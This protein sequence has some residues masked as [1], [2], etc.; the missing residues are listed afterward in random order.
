MVRST[1]SALLSHRVIFLENKTANELEDQDWQEVYRSFAE[2]KPMYD[3]KFGSIEKFNFGHIVTEAFFMFKI[4]FT[5]KINPKMRISFS[6]RIFEIKRIINV[7]EKDKI[8]QII[9]LE[10]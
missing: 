2:I 5:E 10:I 3:N 1:L 8:L 6:R 4:R 9:A 7:L